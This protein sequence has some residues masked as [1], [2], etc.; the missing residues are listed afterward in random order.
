M[1]RYIQTGLIDF[2]LKSH[3]MGKR[4]LKI[5]QIKNASIPGVSKIRNASAY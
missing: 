4:V 1:N 3:L 2:A 5:R